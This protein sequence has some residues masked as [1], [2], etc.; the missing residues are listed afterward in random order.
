M[1]D[2]RDKPEG[3]AE[4]EETPGDDATAEGEERPT[5]APP[6][7]PIQF[8]QEILREKDDDKDKDEKDK[9]AADA[10]NAGEKMP[11]S[12]S[13][14]SAP[15]PSQRTPPR[16]GA[17][18]VPPPAGGYWFEGPF[19][20]GAL[21]GPASL[22]QTPPPS[23]NPHTKATP[24]GGFR[25]PAPTY[26]D[27]DAL[28]EARRKSLE[29]MQRRDTAGALAFVNTTVPS[30]PPPPNTKPAGA[31]PGEPPRKE[32]VSALNAVDAEWADL[33]A[34]TRPPPP[35]QNPEDFDIP[36]RR[37][38]R[39]IGGI[40]NLYE[41]FQKKTPLG[42]KAQ[43][44][45]TPKAPQVILPSEKDE[46]PPSGKKT[47]PPPALVEDPAFLERAKKKSIRQDVPP[48]EEEMNERVALGDYTGALAIAEKL[49]VDDPKNA[50]I[51]SVAENC[52]T[53][54]RQMY[55]TKIGPMDRVPMVMVPRDQ[56]RW[57]SIDHRAGFVLSLVD[58]VSSLEMILDVS[59]MPELDAL[60]ILT[61][62]A[63]QRIIS[64]R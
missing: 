26:T 21:Q 28:E 27:S 60:R 48:T 40:A 30:N 16:T 59:G 46:P 49:L 17:V 41:N 35:G 62:L 32:S 55:I 23:N 53:V 8:A 2:E 54:L 42:T 61:E 45:T 33:E 14:S 24:A 9:S 63:Q 12:K 38:P 43:S 13:V 7:D 57:L 56:L 58:G 39:G 31:V 34:A 25:P 5:A 36:S 20:P 1:T 15:P 6:F 37:E 50:S 11:G 10:R 18:S 51:N 4:E 44:E 19:S 3:G 52:R 22:P 29:M 64:F 47:T